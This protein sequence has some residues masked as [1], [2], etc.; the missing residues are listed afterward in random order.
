MFCGGPSCS[1]LRRACMDLKSGAP[2]SQL[3]IS[4]PTDMTPKQQ[5]TH[6]AAVTCGIAGLPGS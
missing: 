6:C 3:N 2:L 5:A 1:T 4:M